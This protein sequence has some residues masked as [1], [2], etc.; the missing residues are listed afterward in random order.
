MDPIKLNVGDFGDEVARLHENLKPRGPE[1]S[2]EE[3]KRNFF[4]P[5]TSAAVRALQKEHKL[6]VTGVVN[7]ETHA[8][9]MAA[10]PP[11]MR[12][13]DTDLPTIQPN[14][15]VEGIV[16]KPPVPRI[17]PVARNAEPTGPMDTSPHT[18]GDTAPC[19]HPP[20]FAH[21]R[22]LLVYNN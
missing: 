1:I 8:A 17:P 15:V 11:R 18:L 13:I 3:E 2:P 9:L 7:S 14:P 4:G 22:H 12:T 6:P 16:A 5:S 20:W 21:L 19:P 10:V